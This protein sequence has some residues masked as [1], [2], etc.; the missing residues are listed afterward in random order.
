M[1]K[2]KKD[3]NER[4]NKRATEWEKD[5]AYAI[6]RAFF[7]GGN[8]NSNREIISHI[9]YIILLLEHRSNS[10]DFSAFLMQVWLAIQ[11]FCDS[12]QIQKVCFG[13]MGKCLLNTK[14]AYFFQKDIFR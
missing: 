8:T 5:L 10:R 3:G 7:K 6:L 4:K 13:F 2:K 14:P 12:I 9:S 1:E 11:L